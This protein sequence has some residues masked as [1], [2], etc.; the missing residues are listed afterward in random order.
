MADLLMDRLAALPSAAPDPRRSTRTRERCRAT[1]VRRPPLPR[2]D[3]PEPCLRHAVWPQAVTILGTL[4]LVQAVVLA[5][6]FY[7][8]R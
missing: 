8:R 5:L 1:L 3:T 6:Q 4:Y 7:D 2:P